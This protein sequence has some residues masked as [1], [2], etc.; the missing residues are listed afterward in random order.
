MSQWNSRMHM[1]G[2][3]GLTSGT[4]AGSM[5]P[6]EDIRDLEAGFLPFAFVGFVDGRDDVELASLATQDAASAGEERL[7]HA[8]LA[9]GAEAGGGRG[10]LLM[11]VL[12]RGDRGGI[13]RGHGGGRGATRG[14]GGVGGIAPGATTEDGEALGRVGVGGRT[15]AHMDGMLWGVGRGPS[16]GPV[17]VV[18]H[19][20]EGGQ[21]MRGMHGL[22][23]WRAVHGQ[24]EVN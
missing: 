23:G 21:A 10:S 3:R 20:A 18:G 16:G 6:C 2:G 15:R 7:G 17:V 1:R 9:L 5:V 22:G 8:L 11:G 14:G 12:G 13:G 19:G 4:L 24:E